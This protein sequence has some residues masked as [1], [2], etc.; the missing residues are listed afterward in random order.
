M[1]GAG[2]TVRVAVGSA[3]RSTSR[4]DGHAADPLGDPVRLS[5]SH[6]GQAGQI[7]PLVLDAV[8]V[9]RRPG[10]RSRRDR[11]AAPAAAQR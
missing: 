5:R 9:W 10:T 7:R 6:P 11:G 3:S 8:P 4:A 2:G 1:G